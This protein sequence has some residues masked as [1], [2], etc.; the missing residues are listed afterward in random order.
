MILAMF[1]NQ[2]PLRRIGESASIYV[3]FEFRLT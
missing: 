1:K 3:R 2:Q